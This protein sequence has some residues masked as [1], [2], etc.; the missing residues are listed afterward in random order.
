[1]RDVAQPPGRR[2]DVG[3]PR[4]EGGCL[5]R[6]GFPEITWK[7]YLRLVCVI[8]SQRSAVNL[9]IQHPERYCRR[10]RWAGNLPSAENS[11]ARDA[12]AST[13]NDPFRLRSDV[14]EQ[15]VPGDCCPEEHPSAGR[16][17]HR[18][19]RGFRRE[20]SFVPSMWRRPKTDL[21]HESAEA[22]LEPSG[23]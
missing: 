20:R 8:R 16:E 11:R 13:E 21:P 10:R 22:R 9:A 5:R 1:M 15:N 7:P 12:V 2:V 19:D 18:L 17:T 6:S 4:L 14:P 23:E 3:N